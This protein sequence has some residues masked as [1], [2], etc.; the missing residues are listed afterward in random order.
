MFSQPR[1]G[2]V[3]KV[4]VLQISYA[5]V[6]EEC[7]SRVLKAERRITKRKQGKKVKKQTDGEEEEEEACD[8]DSE[9]NL[10]DWDSASSKSEK[11][12]STN[13]GTS[14]GAG[15]KKTRAP[16]AS[17]EQKA[18]ARKA[19]APEV[20]KVRKTLKVL[21]PVVKECKGVLKSAQVTEDIK[22]ELAAAV[23]MIKDS[24]KY[25]KDATNASNGGKVMQPFV[26]NP[27]HAKDLAKAIRSK[28]EGIRQLE[29]V[30]RNMGD[31]GLNKLAAHAKR[32]QEAPNMD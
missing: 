16:K 14:K 31:E 15:R 10:S 2:K 5:H 30:I 9:I 8:D 19:N 25:K 27:D 21:E 11:R 32:I 20:A 12:R 22:Q 1:F 18:E 28:A 13:K 17:N 23:R 6:Q 26:H 4:P 7:R 29:S 24:N 3:Y